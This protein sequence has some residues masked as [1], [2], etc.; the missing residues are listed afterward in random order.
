MDLF[1]WFFGGL[2]R[3]ANGRTHNVCDG[4]CCRKNSKIIIL[5]QSGGEISF[6]AGMQCPPIRGRINVEMHRRN[7]VEKTKHDWEPW[8]D[9]RSTHAFFDFLCDTEISSGSKK[10]IPSF[11]VVK[12]KRGSPFKFREGAFRWSPTKITLKAPN[13]KTD[14]RQKITS[15]KSTANHT[16]SPNSTNSSYITIATLPPS[17]NNWRPLDQLNL[18]LLSESSILFFQ[19][20]KTTTTTSNRQTTPKFQK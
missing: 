12:T 11:N 17:S 9:S 18:Y 8:F 2:S 16:I 6:F 7:M 10:I 13:E 5:D 1:F 4:S 15:K 20:S 3:K 14:W 19:Y